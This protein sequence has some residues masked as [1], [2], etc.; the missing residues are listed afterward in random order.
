MYTNTNT[1]I[2]YFFL[3]HT[4]HLDMVH[5][6]VPLFG[7]LVDTH[8][9]KRF[10]VQ[11]E[12]LWNSVITNNSVLELTRTRLY[13]ERT[14]MKSKII[15][16]LKL[17][18]SRIV[19]FPWRTVSYTSTIVV[20]VQAGLYNDM[21]TISNSHNTTN[22]TLVVIRS[23]TTSCTFSTTTLRIPCDVQVTPSS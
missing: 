21:I 23:H 11:S 10:L 8:S 18:S 22:S 4:L 12:Y 3:P 16:T 15:I 19:Y 9:H 6:H 5:K 1:D 7:N 20:E 2:I 13:T 14:R 17:L